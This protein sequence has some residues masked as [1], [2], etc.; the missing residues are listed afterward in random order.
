MS[1][2]VTPTVPPKRPARWGLRIALIVGGLL[3]ALCC[4]GAT[5]FPV[6]AIGRVSQEMQPARAAADAYVRAVIAG[7]DARAAGYLC[8]TSDTTA[9]HEAFFN[10]VRSKNVT[11]HEIASIHVN[12]GS[13]L[14][15]WSGTADVEVSTTKG[16]GD[17][18]ELPLRK[19]DD[20]WKVCSD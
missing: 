19:E 9:S 17:T 15:G 13:F 10:D 8:G 2:G 5:T 20:K 14:S 12:S 18:W 1:E 11:R 7:D 3:V 6:V 16:V 4:V